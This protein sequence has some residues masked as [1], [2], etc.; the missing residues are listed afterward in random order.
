RL[1][2][3]AVELD[4][5]FGA[6]DEEGVG[7]HKSMEP[8][9]IQVAPVHHIESSG[10]Q[11]QLVQNAHIGLFAGRNRNER[12]NRTAQVQQRVQLD[13]PFAS[14]EPRPRKQMQTKINRGGI[15]RVDCLSEL[16]GQFLVQVERAGASDE[17]LGQVSID[18]P[19]SVVIGVGQSARGD[20]TL[21]S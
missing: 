4:V 10:L 19:V 11:K 1:R 5:G 8:L 16:G 2:F 17:D 18:P 3:Q 9:K 12:R 13:G 15:Q 21:K 6:S 14:P 20:R 7:Q